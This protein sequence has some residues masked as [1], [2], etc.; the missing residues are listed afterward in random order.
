MVF[1]MTVYT[2]SIETGGL[3]YGAFAVS[4][5]EMWV[6]YVIVFVL[7]FFVI[8][9]AAKKLALRIISPE[10]YDPIVLIIAIQS[11]TVMCIVPPITLAAV[12]LHDGFTADWFAKW[13]TKAALC[14]PAAYF[15][16]VFFVG[17][18]VRT[19]FSLMFKNRRD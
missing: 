2:V 7:I 19:V 4:I 16:Q 3:T 17:P 1:C 12:F 6:E 15:L 9:N 10:K 13:I 11:F 8:T 18:L 14:F 5:K